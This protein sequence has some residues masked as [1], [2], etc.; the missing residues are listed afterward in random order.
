MSSNS[1]LTRLPI[2][3][4]PGN[5]AGRSLALHETRAVLVPLVRR[6]DFKFA[7]GFET[8]E[9]ER[10]LKDAYALMRGSMPLVISARK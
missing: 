10:N 8:A 7:E 1:E 5:C 6:F 2:Y 4:G 3:L 9:W